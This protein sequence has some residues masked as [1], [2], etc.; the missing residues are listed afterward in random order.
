M[1][2]A[3]N[4]FILEL[5]FSIKLTMGKKRP[6]QIETLNE[7]LPPQYKVSKP[8]KDG[9]QGNVFLGTLSGEKAAIKIFRPETD[10]RRIKREQ[11]LTKIT[12]PNLVRILGVS[13]M[14][15]NNK[16]C[17]L[18]AYEYY[19]GGDL[20][21]FLSEDAEVLAASVLFKIGQQ[22]SNAMEVLWN[23][24]IVH[25]DIKPANIV[26]AEKDRFVLVDLGIARHLD[27]VTVTLRGHFCGTEGYMSPEQAIG[28]KNLTI[29]SDVF[30]LGITLYELASKIHPF[31]RQQDMI[32]QYI[33]KPLNADRPDLPQKFSDLLNQMM[34]SRVSDRPSLVQKHFSAFLED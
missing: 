8:I 33:P 28:R 27:L 6:N 13:E 10:P 31:D 11:S 4:L 5:S 2:G 18:I 9:G 32:G 22:I 30:S 15:I 12:C 34:A 19:E 14:Q 16:N 25:R 26:Q 20:T 23:N 24:R 17:S 29:H 3:E 1:I 7:L 21:K